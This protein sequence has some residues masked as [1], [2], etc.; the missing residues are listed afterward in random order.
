MGG[1]LCI[2]DLP[3]RQELKRVFSLNKTIEDPCVEEH[4]HESYKSQNEIS[5]ALNSPVFL[6]T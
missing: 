2:E 5:I 3:F 1:L 6:L 4:L